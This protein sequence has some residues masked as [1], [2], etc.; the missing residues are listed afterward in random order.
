[1]PDNNGYRKQ[2]YDWLLTLDTH[3]KWFLEKKVQKMDSLDENKQAYLSK[4]ADEEDINAVVEM[5]W[6]IRSRLSAP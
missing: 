3:I 5:F 6:H 1:M 4:Y 2:F